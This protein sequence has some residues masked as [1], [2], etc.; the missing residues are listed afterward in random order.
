MVDW[1]FTIRCVQAIAP[2]VGLTVNVLVQ[3][4]ACRWVKQLSLMRSIYLG[5]VAGLLG[6]ALLECLYFLAIPQSVSDALSRLA[7]NVATYGALGYGYFIFVTLGETG[8]RIRIVRELYAAGR[9]LTR[10]E[11]LERYNAEAIVN[12][13]INRLLGTGQIAFRD[14]R[15]YLRKRTVL[16]MARMV[17]LMKLLVLGKRSEFE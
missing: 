5:F 8:R 15:Y 2:L 17:V 12:V 10:D 7:L 6:L 14:G 13:R 11:I 16:T 1:S 3:L 9:P 4:A